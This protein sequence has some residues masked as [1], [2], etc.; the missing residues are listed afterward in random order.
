MFK[1]LGI[2]TLSGAMLMGCGKSTDNSKVIA[3][4]GKDKI[5][6]NYLLAALKARHRNT[7]F[8]EADKEKNI[9]FLNT[10]IE[11]K[12]LTLAAQDAGLTKIEKLAT[13]AESLRKRIISQKYQEIHLENRGG[14]KLSTLEKFYQD[15]QDMFKDDS[16][17]VI[18][19]E[20]AENQVVE[21][22]L[23]KDV[24]LE[25]YYEENK[26]QFAKIKGEDTTYTTLEENRDQVEKMYV[27][28][29]RRD[30]VQGLRERL[31]EKYAVEMHKPNSNA[32]E[33]ELKAFYEEHK[34]RYM[35]AELYEVYHI[36][37]ETE[38]KAMKALEG[39]KTLDD[40]KVA[41][42]KYSI[43]E[44]TKPN[45]GYVGLIKNAHCLPYGIG[46]FPRLFPMLDSLMQTSETLKL[47]PALNNPQSKMWHSFAVVKKVD[48]TQ[49]PYER[50]ASLVK[51]NFFSQKGEDVAP[52][53][54][55]ATYKPNG[56]IIEQDVLTL[57]EEIPPHYQQR[58]TREQLV[59]FLILWELSDLEAKE[60]GLL[61]DNTLDATIEMEMNNY[62][63]KVYQ[64]SVL[65][66]SFGLDSATLAKTFE[67]NREYFMPESPNASYMPQMDK[68]IAIFRSIDPEEI[69][70][71]YNIHPE[72]YMKDS[73]QLS[74]D[75][76]KY[77]IFQNLR[78]KFQNRPFENYVENLKKKY[79]VEIVD[80]MFIIPPLTD[81][82]AEF[83]TAQ[84][85]HTDRKLNDAL[86]QY[87][88][89]REAFP[90]NKTLQDSI[91]M[92]MAQVN[93]ELE[94]YNDALSEYR[95][96]LYLYPD[97][98][99][100]YKAQF[101]IGFIF[102]ENLKKDGPAIAAFKE[103]LEKYP[104]CDLADD[105]DWMI[106]NIESGGALMPVLEDS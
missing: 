72:K 103:L 13:R 53:A 106:R 91:C 87:R 31:N 8:K 9:D 20:K 17:K 74:F 19:F 41:A 16:N 23:L 59:D 95:R 77:K 64:D 33:E 105:A 28:M 44:W 89:I 25:D 48:K 104:K 101:M 61:S 62:W 55:L 26:V 84:Q 35:N 97:S 54:V 40:F 49:K 50:V 45:G 71:E 1:L 43:N 99:N 85:L 94:K 92:G 15:N 38:E 34:D 75:E 69:K 47:A 90:D 76:A 51:E 86:K 7:D 6:E 37:T 12:V 63:S 36:E 79:S 83:K 65:Q 81:P 98:P 22:Y 56:K 78:R 21:A 58:Y 102:A 100:N 57:R 24:N 73:T 88:K 2:F 32:K 67:E 68:S 30:L 93:V 42:G 3:K 14:V 4:V 39:V 60:A 10:L 66:E 29:Y 80:S 96:L 5:T 82:Q 18:P 11:S 52:D 46:M 70:L 27:R